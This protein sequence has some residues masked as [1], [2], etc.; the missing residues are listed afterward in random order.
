MTIWTKSTGTA[1]QLQLTLIES[2]TNSGANTSS[3]HVVA[4]IYTPAGSF[5]SGSD[6]SV[7]LSGDATWSTGSWSFGSGGGWHTLYDDYVTVG[8]N[9]NGTGSASVTFHLNDSTGTSGVGGPASVSGTLTLTTLAVTPGQPTGLTAARASDSQ[10]NL[11][12]TRHYT[13]NGVPTDTNC[14]K[15]INNSGTWV[16]VAASGNIS[17]MSVA[18]SANQKLIFRV[19]QS[20]GA[21]T[22]P[23]SANS[24]AVW[25][26]PAAPS[27]CVAAKQSDGSVLVTWTNHVAYSEYVTQV[28]HGTISGG[29][30]TWDSTPLF[31]AA[32]GAAA[33][34]HAAP[35]PTKVH[36]YEVRAKT[37][38][39]ATLYS[40]YAVSNTVQ[41]LTA[42][43]APGVADLPQYADAAVALEVDWTHQSADS[44]GQTAYEF[45]HSTDGGTTWTSTGKTTGTD[46]SYTIPASTYAANTALVIRV[47]TWGAA[48]TGGSDG[49][50]G[51]PW[52]AQQTITFKTRPTVTI[53]E[54]SHTVNLDTANLVVMLTF[55]QAE[56][57]TAVHTTLQLFKSGAQIEQVDTRDISVVPF[58]TRLVNGGD[59]SV[60][61]YATDSNG[62]T[63]D[64][65]TVDFGVT[66]APPAPATIDA[67]YVPEAGMMQLAVSFPDPVAPQVSA[68]TF[69][70]LRT[71]DDGPTEVITA[72]QTVVGDILLLDTT[73]TINGDNVYEVVTWTA[74]GASSDPVIADAVTTEARWAFLS[75]GDGFADYVLFFGDLTV[76]ST[77]QRDSALIK[78]AGRSRPIALFGDTSTL[79]IA[80][81][82]TILTDAGSSPQQIEEMLLTA[83]LACFRDPSGRRIFGLLSNASIA[84]IGPRFASLSFTISEAT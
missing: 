61:A 26:T 62:L 78:A 40:G 43:L 83:G 39:G 50:G 56:G 27:S 81:T 45:S 10:I 11:S 41:L 5:H 34:E 57:A 12:W 77:P 19:D 14:Q 52:S 49:L 58:G 28:W 48:T 71:I 17:S 59:Y 64:V 4:K 67:T 24:N 68:A 15:Q 54:P 51:S 37:S 76:S 29:T 66:F 69:V 20:N 53:T 42:P 46:S 65:D 32:S 72:P 18:V 73:P 84:N 3:V 25:T 31:S 82:A 22:S 16:N 63:S 13:S 9:S 6:L 1:G 33:Y 21:G 80:V 2:S 36:I 38:S 44:S 70:I 8:H 79:D 75:T 7:S 35:D 55:D 60:K 30:T 23:W 74:D 47:R